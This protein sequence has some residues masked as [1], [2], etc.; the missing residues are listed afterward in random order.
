MAHGAWYLAILYG[1]LDLITWCA[2]FDFHVQIV[3][4]LFGIEL[5]VCLAMIL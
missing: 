1:F 3:T 4:A 5:C 2:C